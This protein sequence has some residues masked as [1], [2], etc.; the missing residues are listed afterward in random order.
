MGNFTD[1]EVAFLRGKRL[2]HLA[3][4]NARGEP[5]VVPVGYVFDEATETL[6]IGGKGMSRSKKFREALGN[7]PIA[8]VV[9]GQNAQGQPCGVETRGRA[10]IAPMGGGALRSGWDEEHILLRPAR[11]VAWGIDTDPYSPANSRRVE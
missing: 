6:A 2:G 1:A 5:H 7:A 3:T 10:E 4:V 11:I 9:D 8:F